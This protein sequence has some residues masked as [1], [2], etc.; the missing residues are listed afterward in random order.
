MKISGL[1]LLPRW[2]SSLLSFAALSI[3]S[4]QAVSA[5]QLYWRRYSPDHIGPGPVFISPVG[6]I[7]NGG[8]WMSVDVGRSPLSIC[9][10]SDGPGWAYGNYYNGVC[11]YYSPTLNRGHDIS[12][13]FDLLGGTRF[14]A[15]R[16]VAR[17]DDTNSNSAHIVDLSLGD[18][19]LI[20]QQ[21]IQD[22]ELESLCRIQESDGAFI[23]TQREGGC[24]ASWNGQILIS[25]D[26]EVVETENR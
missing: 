11:A 3:V 25:A 14:P 6:N 10:I 17:L 24:F 26:Y 20:Q 23:G 5:D 21:A 1:N 15:W 4:V 9:R 7:W 16:H 22:G 12:I 19:S 2:C 18:P 13:G 8:W